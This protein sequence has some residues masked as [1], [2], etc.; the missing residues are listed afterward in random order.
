MRPTKH[1]T[2]SGRK[3]VRSCELDLPSKAEMRQIGRWLSGRPDRTELPKQ[4]NIE[5]RKRRNRARA[6]AVERSIRWQQANREAYNA[7]MRAWRKRR[8]LA[9]GEVVG[10]ADEAS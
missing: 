6:K 2:L 3:A 7:R 9:G 8:R 4:N 5:E 10:G 1:D